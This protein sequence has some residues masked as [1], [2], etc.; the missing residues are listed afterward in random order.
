MIYHP[1]HS[2]THKDFEKSWLP[3]PTWPHRFEARYEQSIANGKAYFIRGQS[4]ACNP[5]AFGKVAGL[6]R[7]AV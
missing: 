2:Y 4:G 3:L 5:A 6:G 1:L 7:V